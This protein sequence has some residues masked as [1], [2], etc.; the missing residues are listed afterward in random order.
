MTTRTPGGGGSGGVPGTPGGGGSGGG[1]GGVPKPKPKPNPVLPG[2]N[3]PPPA[4]KPAK[5]IVT[6]VQEQN[7]YLYIVGYL[8]LFLFLMLIAKSK[9]GY[10][11]LYYALLL[12]IL[13]VAVTEFALFAPL[14]IGPSL[15]QTQ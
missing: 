3:N 2:D 4:K 10:T 8:L 9:V 1:S 13:F 14:L 6:N 7:T 11:L 12:M 15:A 5:G